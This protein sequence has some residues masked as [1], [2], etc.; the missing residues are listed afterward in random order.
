MLSAAARSLVRQP[1][2]FLAAVAT[3]ALGIG[4]AT[5]LFTTVDAALLTPLPYSR[6]QDIYTVRTFFPTGR[7]TIG[8]MA[9]EEMSA[10]ARLDDVVAA[11]ALT[12]RSDSALVIESRARQVVAC[13]V[14]GGFFDL[15]GLPMS[16]GR[17]IAAADGVRGAAPVAVL[18]H[19]LW[20]A[21]FAGREDVLGSTID[22]GDQRV[23]V[24]GIAPAG[25]DM[26]A[27]T[28]IW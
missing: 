10:L 1:S 5:T 14:S 23:R 13:G 2:F 15:F 12:I 17:A 19:G 28:A 6:P 8:L 27:S 7:F 26:P 11:T 4:A 24:V 21:A 18:S 25:F 9:P 22:L 16:R 20:T 3:L